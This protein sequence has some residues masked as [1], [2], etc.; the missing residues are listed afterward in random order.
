MG[1]GVNSSIP[2]S[3]VSKERVLKQTYFDISTKEF[4]FQ[5][6]RAKLSYRDKGSSKAGLKNLSGKREAKSA[7]G[8]GIELTKPSWLKTSVQTSP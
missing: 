2:I 3:I 6:K 8:S 1:V 7:Q 4:L 5:E